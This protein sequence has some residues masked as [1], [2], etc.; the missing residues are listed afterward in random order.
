MGIDTY[1]MTISEMLA[2]L[3]AGQVTSVDLVSAQLNRLGYYDRTG[4][5]LNAVPVLNPDALAEAEFSDLR[6][7]QGQEPRP[8]EGIPFTVKDSYMVTGLTVASGSPALKDLMATGDAATAQMLRAAG[9][10][11]LGKTNMPPMAAGGVQS[12]VYGY[13]ISPYHPGYLTAG[14]GSGSSNG[15]GTATAA[16]I[17]AFGMGEETLSSGRSPASNN[18]LVAYTP[19][20]G[21]ISIRGNWP[22]RPTCDVVVPHTRTVE[23]ML[24]VLDVIVAEDEHTLGDFWRHQTAVELPSVDEVRPPSFLRSRSE[25]LDGLRLGVPRMFLGEDP[26]KT[27]SV[28]VRPSVR[29]LWE[30]AAADLTALGAEVIPVDFPVVSHYEEDRPGTRGLAARGLVHER[31]PEAELGEVLAQSLEDFLAVNAGGALQSWA[32]VE[33]DLVFPDPPAAVYANARASFDWQ[34]LVELVKEGLP[35]ADEIPGYAESLRG[36]EEARKVDFEDWL[37][38]QQL[39]AV[40]FPANGDVGRADLFTHVEHHDEA[41]RNGVVFS[42][43]GWVFRHLGIPTVTVPMGRMADTAMPVGLTIAGPAYSDDRLF[44]IAWSYETSTKHRATPPSAPGLPSDRIRSSKGP[45]Y[46]QHQPA[47]IVI[48][49]EAMATSEGWEVRVRIEAETDVDSAEVWADGQKLT[50]WDELQASGTISS[51]RPRTSGEAL[52]VVKARL[53]SGQLTGVS[54]LVELPGWDGQV[55]P[56]V[57]PGDYRLA[58]ASG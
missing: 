2:A 50:R 42:N 52:V 6:R 24:R 40:V 8:L 38:A 48:E 27:N 44:D 41:L 45:D 30:E 28:T 36:L 37:V 31:W 33:G 26:H 10:V 4:V 43:G 51:A 25:R 12:G 16:N 58:P 49:H 15:S 54:D 21:L 32:E 14:Y 9:A 57:L 17:G 29:T 47:G 35:S 11:L 34:K 53:A 5:C 20:R 46:T 13:A 7:A 39:D 22:L 18:S 19:S 3:E 56:H 23:D 1:E 55:Y